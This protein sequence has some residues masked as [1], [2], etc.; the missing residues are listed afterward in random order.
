MNGAQGMGI[1]LSHADFAHV[2]DEPDEALFAPPPAV[3]DSRGAPA[4]APSA[5]ASPRVPPPSPATAAG[6]D[7]VARLRRIAAAAGDRT[8]PVLNFDAPARGLED[9]LEPASPAPG[10]GE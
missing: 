6:H 3:R 1:G 2:A 7:L 9:D 10:A 8:L 5:P 4:P